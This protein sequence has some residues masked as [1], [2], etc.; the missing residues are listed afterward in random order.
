MKIYK[1]KIK[2]KNLIPPAIVIVLCYLLRLSNPWTFVLTSVYCFWL[3]VN[4]IEIYE[5]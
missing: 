3:L 4:S 1:L 5:Q 2:E